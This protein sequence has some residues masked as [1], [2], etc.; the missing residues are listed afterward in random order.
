MSVKSTKINENFQKYLADAYCIPCKLAMD[1]TDLHIQK[2]IVLDH[3][4]NKCYLLS[5]MNI[6]SLIPPIGKHSI[7]RLQDIDQ[8]IPL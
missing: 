5:S 6:S 4:Y 7:V 2:L 3:H 1:Q 8:R